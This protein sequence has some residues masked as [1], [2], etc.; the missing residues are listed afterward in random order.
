MSK[1]L[2]TR[3]KNGDRRALNELI[4][5]HKDFAYT[6]A[7]QHTKNDDDAKD[8]VQNA[9][10]QVFKS[11]KGFRKEAQF[12][13]WLYKIVY[14]EAL[15]I[16]Q[17]RNT[18]SY[19]SEL[20]IDTSET[21]EEDESQSKVKELM[22]ILNEQEYLVTALFY[23]K[24]KSIKEIIQITNLSKSNVKVILHRARIKLKQKYNETKN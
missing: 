22:S 1:E 13:T 20:V 10:I 6:I 12:S 5:N 18:E 9:F 8:S 21:I 4:D 15:R 24:E 23:L 3:A 14:R 7:L 2:I 16:V 19:S 11:I 17:K